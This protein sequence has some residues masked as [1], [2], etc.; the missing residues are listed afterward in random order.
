MTQQERNHGAEERFT[1]GVTRLISQP[2]EA[3]FITLLAHPDKWSSPRGKTPTSVVIHCTATDN[4][5]SSTANYFHADNT[6]GSTQAVADGDQGFTCVPDDAVCA[7]APPLNQEGLHI[8]QPGLVTWSRETWLSKDNQLRRVA[9]HVAQW[10]KRYSI[11][12]VLLHAADLRRLGETGPGITYHA[13]VTEAFHQSTHTDPGPNYP[14]DVFMRYVHEYIG[15]D[16]ELAVLS[17][18]QQNYLVGLLRYLNQMGAPADDAPDK[19]KE[20]FSESKARLSHPESGGI[21]PAK[22]ARHRHGLSGPTGT[23][24][25][26]AQ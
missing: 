17:E 4:P 11:P 16:D 21:D 6:S 25:P 9:Y 19:V 14:W 22:Y 13:A 3:P 20:G 5:A 18:D 12:P 23:P 2:I 10:C 7:G 8:E 24:V 15:G 1:A 26:D